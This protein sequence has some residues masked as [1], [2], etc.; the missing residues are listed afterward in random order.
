MGG[1]VGRF[2]FRCYI[3]KVI[4]IREFIVRFY[5]EELRS[6]GGRTEIVS[7][8]EVMFCRSFVFRTF[9]G[10]AGFSMEG[11]LFLLMFF[12]KFY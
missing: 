1:I 11:R 4:E 12:G 10:Y 2:F 8:R 7:Y 6:L 5:V 9:L 3:R